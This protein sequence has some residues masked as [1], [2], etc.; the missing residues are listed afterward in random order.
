M[1]IQIE[2]QTVL[3]SAAEAMT[4]KH[5]YLVE[6]DPIIIQVY[7]TALRK[8][9]FLVTV[10][11]DGLVA[12]KGLS[13][14]CPDLVVLDVM[15]P[16]VDGTYVLKYIRSRPELSGT[17]VII[18]SNASIA[19]AGSEAVAQHP[20]AI[21]LKSQCTPSL[22]AEKVCELLNLPPPAPVAPTAQ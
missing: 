20:D 9:G 19:D 21:F 14:L 5:I 12:M 16:K 18:L 11:E 15:M 1:G 4:M 6:D 10:A 22:L 13:Q 3:R 7:C 8:R 17:K 2:Q